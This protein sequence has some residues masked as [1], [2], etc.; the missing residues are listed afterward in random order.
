MQPV[1]EQTPQLCTQH[2]VLT[3]RAVNSFGASSTACGAAVTGA[4]L[5]NARRGII[6][7]ENDFIAQV[8]GVGLKG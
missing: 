4:T 8:N 7:A 6:M 3:C 2:R 1:V 5:I